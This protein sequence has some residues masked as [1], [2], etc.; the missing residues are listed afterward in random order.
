MSV[1]QGRHEPIKNRLLPALPADEY[2]RLVPD[3]KFVSLS[4]EQV[5]YESGEPIRYVYFPHQALVSL[6]STMEDGSTVEV[7]LVGSEGLVGIPVFLGGNTTTNRA[8]VQVA[9]SGMRMEASRL[10][11]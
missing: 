9:D 2:Q 5:L 1:S 7:G 8:F 10:L 3:L 6:V 4:L 11:A